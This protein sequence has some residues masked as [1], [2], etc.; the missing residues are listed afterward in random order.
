MEGVDFDRPLPP[1][2]K[3]FDALA[4]VPVMMIRGANSDLL[5]PATV[6]AMQ[7]RR[8]TLETVEVPDQGHAPLLAEADVIGRIV[9]FAGRCDRA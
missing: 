2:W 5:S 1:L 6:E 7:A 8:K 4:S 3:E 9:E